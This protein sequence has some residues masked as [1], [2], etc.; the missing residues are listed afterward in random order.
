M[1]TINVKPIDTSKAEQYRQDSALVLK[2][3]NEIVIKDQPHYEEAA[4]LLQL[5]KGKAKELEAL[6][7]SITQPLDQA[8][9]AVMD[10][11]RIPQTNYATAE[12]KLKTAMI[13]YTDEQENKRKAEEE[14]LRKE[15]EAKEAK[16]K[17][18]LLKRAEK[19]EANGKIDKAEELREQAEDVTV[20]APNLAP[21][22]ERPNGISYKEKWTAE[23]VDFKALPDTYKIANM[24][25]L[26]KVARDR[27]GIVPI[28]G[29]KFHSEKVVASA[30]I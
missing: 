12:R 7:K 1:N 5:I 9:K 16:E 27:K 17:E 19:A 8:K 25:M 2:E 15:A 28:P 20:I 30:S 24:Q 22:T 23:V 26:N 4:G 18:K 29:V 3:S 21:T 13:T 6:R 11:F 10:L 14:R